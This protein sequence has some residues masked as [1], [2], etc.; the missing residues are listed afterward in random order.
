MMRAAL[1]TGSGQSVGYQRAGTSTPLG[2]AAETRAI[3]QV[4][5]DTPWLA[6]SSTSRHRPLLRTAGA[7]QSMMCVLALHPAAADDQLPESDP[8]RPRHVPAGAGG[9]LDVALSN[10]MG[11]GGATAR[12][13]RPR[14]N[15]NALRTAAR[16]LAG[17]RA[18]ELSAAE[19][20]FRLGCVAG[21]E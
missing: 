13:A 16:L 8:V 2:D 7:I 11:L 17:E 6:I 9:Q 19:R 4:F 12:A 21:H 1:G 14:L 3:K 18:H 5:G 10:A 20:A 15:P